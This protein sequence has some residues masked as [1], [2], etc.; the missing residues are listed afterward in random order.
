MERNIPELEELVLL[1]EYY[2]ENVINLAIK[3]ENTGQ[4]RRAFEVY[5][6]GIEVAERAKKNLSEAMMGLLD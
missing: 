6:N 1:Q 3:L 5:Q 4:Y 2:Y